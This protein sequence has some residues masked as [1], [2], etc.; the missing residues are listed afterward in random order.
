MD[1]HPTVTDFKRELALLAALR[2][3]LKLK[4]HLAHAELKTQLD[5]LERRWLLV[6]E[7]VD[8]S[9]R[10]VAQDGVLVERKIAVLLADLK[11]GFQ[12]AKRAFNTDR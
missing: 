3:E 1:A 9:K 10:H 7:E 8:R 12:N 11:L 4:A 6:A 2:D 5:E